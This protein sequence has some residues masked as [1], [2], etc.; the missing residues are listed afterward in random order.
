MA[1][2]LEWTPRGVLHAEAILRESPVGR[3]GPDPALEPFV[4]HYWPIAWDLREPVVRETLP[5]PTVHLVI[6]AGRSGL[7]GP[8]TARFVRTLEGRGRVLGVK[9]HPGGFRPFWH[10]PISALADRVLPLGEAFGPA[11]QALETRVLD[12]GD[13]V[14]GAVA[15]LEGFLLERLPQSDPQACFARELVQ[16]ILDDPGLQRVEALA[17]IS[18]LSLRG[19]QRLFSDYVGVSPKWVIRRYRLHEAL[20]RLDA[21]EPMDLAALAQELGYFDQAHFIHDFKALLGRTPATYARERDS[22]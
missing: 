6:E 5:H 11:G 7:A 17:A 16:H 10:G 4:Q 22:W 2:P 18:G 9:F 15:A 13:D 3:Y 1:T 20:A 21:R 12:L 8:A 19:L 14:P